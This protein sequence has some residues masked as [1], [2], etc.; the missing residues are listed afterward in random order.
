[1]AENKNN[2]PPPSL[3]SEELRGGLTSFLT[4][5]WL[6]IEPKLAE[7][8]RPDARIQLTHRQHSKRFLVEYKTAWTAASLASAIQQAKRYSKLS[9]GDF[10]LVVVPYLSEDAVDTLLESD[11]SGLDLCGNGALMA[12]DWLLLFSG[13]PNRFKNPQLTKSPYREKSSLVAR[14]LLSCPV[15]P[16]AEL[17]RN[18]IKRRGGDISQPVV[19]RALKAFRDDLIVGSR[20]DYNVVLL[21]PEKLLDRLLE[22]WKVTKERWQK[23]GQNIVWTGR[24]DDDIPKAL[25]AVFANAQR[26]KQPTVMAGLSSSGRYTNLTTEPIQYI[27][28]KNLNTLLE[29]VDAQTTRRFPNI[30]IQYPPD[31]TVFFDPITDEAGVKWA[32][33][34]QTYL[35]LAAGDVRLQQAARAFRTALL[36]EVAEK[37]DALLAS[38][39]QA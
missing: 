23:S 38:Q 39:E 29:G 6:E 14:T 30:E 7:G 26:S 24:A 1:M 8:K 15:A 35:E 22:Q 28:S 25:S 36:N 19:S 21:Q 32:S 10:P 5:D 34:L 2:R 9:P 27:Y 20:A 16:T 3:T 33:R 11:V 18:E 4:L 37:K 13:K 17:L 31:E 12:D